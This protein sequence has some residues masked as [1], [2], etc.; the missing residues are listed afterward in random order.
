MSEHTEQYT[1]ILREMLE[2]D[3][4]ALT[5]ADSPQ[6]I[7]K[8]NSMTHMKLIARFE[9]AYGVKFKV[10]QVVRV[11]SIGDLRSLLIEQGVELA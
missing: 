5:D 8:W 1:T 7:A 10:R 2:V 4:A 6:T 9:S 11:K 3:P